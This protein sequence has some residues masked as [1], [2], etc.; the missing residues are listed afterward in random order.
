MTL[1]TLMNAP[2]PTSIVALD[3]MHG[4]LFIF[5]ADGKSAFYPDAMLYS[6]LFLAD[7]I[8][9]QKDEGSPT[10]QI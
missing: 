8:S 2:A 5:F 3:R 7:P 4:G 10:T 6:L 9:E 1:I